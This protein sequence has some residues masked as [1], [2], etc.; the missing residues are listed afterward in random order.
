[1]DF[2][3][4]EGKFQQ[5]KAGFEDGELTETEFKAQLEELMVQDEGGSWWMIGYETEQWYRHDGENWVQA[6][7]PGMPSKITSP[8]V[9]PEPQADEDVSVKTAHQERTES[10]QV[11]KQKAM[12][13]PAPVQAPKPKS[14][15]W[16][17]FGVIG[18]IAVV[19]CIAV[20]AWIFSLINPPVVQ[21]VTPEPPATEEPAPTEE[22]A[23]TEEPAPEEIENSLNGTWVGLLD[24]PAKDFDYNFDMT[25]NQDYNSQTFTG[26]IGFTCANCNEE[27]YS[28]LDGTWDGFNFRFRESEGRHFWGTYENGHMIGFV[29]WNCYDCSHWGTFDLEKSK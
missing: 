26:K 24:E 22:P 1:M 25:I 4:A 12:R 29:A 11:Q 19:L 14:R 23:L 10:D 8:A 20:G 18:F 2:Q 7:P 16:M 17:V 6:D 21:K 3:Q 13:V 28:I 15:N 27:N 5:L 9:T